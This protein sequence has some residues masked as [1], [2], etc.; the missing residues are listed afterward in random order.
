MC[1]VRGSLNARPRLR[2]ALLLGQ[3]FFGAEPSFLAAQ[4]IGSQAC[5][6]QQGDACRPLGTLA[7]IDHLCV[8]TQDR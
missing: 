1:A 6:T 4:A 5:D 2:P 8:P 3:K 7:C